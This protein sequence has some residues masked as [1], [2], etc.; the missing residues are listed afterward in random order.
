MA[1]NVQPKINLAGGSAKEFRQ[2]GQYI[3]QV[4]IYLVWK[5]L[6]PPSIK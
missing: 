4:Q 1:R 2:N 6:N 5:E 3:A